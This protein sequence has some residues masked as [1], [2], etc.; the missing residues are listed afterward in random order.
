MTRL[1]IA[2]VVVA[3][4]LAGCGG[5]DESASSPTTRTESPPLPTPTATPSPTPPTATAPS[6]PQPPADAMKGEDQPGGAGDEEEARVPVRLVVDGEGITPPS[7]AIPAFIALRLTVRN[8][9]PRP[10]RIRVRAAEV[11]FS[12]PARGRRTVE[13]SGLRPGRYAVDA[14][15]AGRAVLVSGAEA[16]P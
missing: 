7:V 13:A 9:L 1:A 10:V 11:A 15:A 5:D 16:G 8:D 14:G 3:A 2:A 4:V 6:A 12:V